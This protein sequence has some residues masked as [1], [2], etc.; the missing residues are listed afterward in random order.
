MLAGISFFPH[1][2]AGPIVRGPD[3][4]PQLKVRRNPRRLDM[5]RAVYLVFAGLF[6]A[7][8]MSGAPSGR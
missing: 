1:L 8:G 7:R 6:K 5:S 4:L 2:V 3:L